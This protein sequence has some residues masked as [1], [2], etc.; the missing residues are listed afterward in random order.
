M[1]KRLQLSWVEIPRIPSGARETRP[2]HVQALFYRQ[3]STP[4][5]ANCADVPRP[6]QERLLN[7]SRSAIRPGRN[8]EELGLPSQ[9]L[10][11]PRRHGSSGVVQRV[12]P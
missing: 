5:G 11:T 1:K 8:I 12:I 4:D 9:R 3:I 7:F 10:R 2:A 6:L